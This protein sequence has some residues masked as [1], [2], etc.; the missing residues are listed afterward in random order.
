M[1]ISLRSA[2]TQILTSWS[3]APFT[4]YRGA[5]QADKATIIEQSVL[6]SC[7]ELNSKVSLPL[8]KNDA[9]FYGTCE[10]DT[11]SPIIQ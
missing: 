7:P 1:G 10:R 2:A 5:E 8:K 11:H 9:G 4:L 6:W 3:N